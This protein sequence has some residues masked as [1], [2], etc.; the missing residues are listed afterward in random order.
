MRQL[1]WAV[2]VS[3][4]TMKKSRYEKQEI[5]RCI[6]EVLPRARTGWAG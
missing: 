3:A 1:A 6:I 5:A 4:L 2:G